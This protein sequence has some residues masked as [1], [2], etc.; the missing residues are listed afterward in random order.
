MRIPGADQAIGH[1][2]KWAE[3]DEWAL[4]RRQV[5]AEHSGR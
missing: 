5:F 2:I 1:L 4:Y 3:K